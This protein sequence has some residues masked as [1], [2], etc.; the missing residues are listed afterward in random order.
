MAIKDNKSNTDVVLLANLTLTADGQVTTG[1]LDGADY[2]NGITFVPAL[3]IGDGAT[4]V[5]IDE[6]QDSPDG[7]TWSSV[8]SNQLIG[9]I[10]DFVFITESA[11]DDTLKTLGVIGT[12]RYVR[13]AITTSNYA[14]DATFVVT[15]NAGI[16][17]SPGNS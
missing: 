1:A 10:S 15:V 12:E 4:T 11:A 6:V 7:S 2:D 14:T 8:P 3:V 16:E 13:L 17:V 5:T 9:D